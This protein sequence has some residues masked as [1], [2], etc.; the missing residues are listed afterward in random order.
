MISTDLRRLRAHYDVTVKDGNFVIYISHLDSNKAILEKADHLP[1][2]HPS[3]SPLQAHYSD[4]IIRAIASQIA[5]VSVVCATVSWSADQRKHQ[6]S[7]S[8]VFVRGIYQWSVDSP[9]K[10]PVTQNMLPFDDVI[11]KSWRRETVFQSFLIALKVSKRLDIT[12]SAN[13]KTMQ[14]FNTQSRRFEN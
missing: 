8:L 5:G 7:A 2:S 6:S 14:K 1:S 11:M 3:P 10:G 13:F 9:H 12:G 4:V